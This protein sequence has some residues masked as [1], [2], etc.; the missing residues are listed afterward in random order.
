[1]WCYR[2][3]KNLCKNTA[4]WK[5]QK[6]YNFFFFILYVEKCQKTVE[7]QMMIRYVTLVTDSQWYLP[8]KPSTDQRRKR[9][10]NL[11]YKNS[12]DIRIIQQ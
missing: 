1:M 8:F 7:Q 2:N 6:S 12:S 3:I 9:K 11:F 4:K 10:P 5:L